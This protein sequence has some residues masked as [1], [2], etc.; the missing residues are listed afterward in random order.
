MMYDIDHGDILVSTL[1]LV[2]PAGS[3]SMQHTV[4]TGEQQ[5]EGGGIST[6]LLALSQVIEALGNRDRYV[7]YRGSSLTMLL[8]P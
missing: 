5:K 6:S 3:E 8:Q 2:D 4:A 7:P 1:N